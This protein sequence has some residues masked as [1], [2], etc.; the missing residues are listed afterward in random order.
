MDEETE[1]RRVNQIMQ[2]TDSRRIA[3]LLS[4]N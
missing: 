4:E 3:M 2:E 1:K